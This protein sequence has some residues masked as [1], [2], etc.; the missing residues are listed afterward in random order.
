[1]GL[2]R[3]IGGRVS[4]D[5]PQLAV[6]RPAEGRVRDDKPAD[7]MVQH[8][9]TEIGHGGQTERRAWSSL[10]KYLAS[11]GSSVRPTDLMRP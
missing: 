1:M 9:F 2:F 4:A 10:A 8:L 6:Q 7:E 3:W 11:Q 5:R